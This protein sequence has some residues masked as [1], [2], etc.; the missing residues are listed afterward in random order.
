MTVSENVGPSPRRP[1]RLWPGIGIVAVQWLTIL[2]AP[3]VLEEGGILAIMVGAGAGLLVLLWWLFFSRALW[4]DRLGA[5]VLMV[6]TVLLAYQVVHPSISNGLM[7]RMVPVFSIPL[8]SLALV[9]SVAFTR[10]RPDGV[11]R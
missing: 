9:V 10:R 7:G 4:V 8:L 1:L 3:L 11:R 2:L 6:L 5:V